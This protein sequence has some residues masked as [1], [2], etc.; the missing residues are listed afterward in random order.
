[1]VINLQS[2]A[3]AFL[4]CVDEKRCSNNM[5]YIMSVQTLTEMWLYSTKSFDGDDA[6]IL[7]KKIICAMEFGLK[8]MKVSLL[9]IVAKYDFNLSAAFY[10][11]SCNTRA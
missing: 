4:K 3:W 5:K 9:P 6:I 10:A 7:L 2:C 11:V 8:G 1:M